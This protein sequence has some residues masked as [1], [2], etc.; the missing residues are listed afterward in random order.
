M[1]GAFWDPP[2]MTSPGMAATF[3]VL[4]LVEAEDEEAEE[5]G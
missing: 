3:L 2:E 4:D 1:G 5:D